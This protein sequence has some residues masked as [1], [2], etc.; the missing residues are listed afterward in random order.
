[1]WRSIL[2]VILMP[3][4]LWAQNPQEMGAEGKSQTP[5]S[6]IVEQKAPESTYQAFTQ[7]QAIRRGTTEKA[8]LLFS[9][10][11]DA[12]ISPR[13]RGDKV[14]PLK[15][16]FTSSDGLRIS[17]FEFPPDTKNRFDLENERI[18]LIWG[19]EAAVRFKVSA[20][21]NAT[22]GDRVLQGKLTYQ[23][24]RD[25]VPLPAQEIAVQLP[26]TV[27]DHD[28]AANKNP[29]Y[30]QRFGGTPMLVWILAPV[31][32]PIVAVIILGCAIVR[33]DCSE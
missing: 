14:I 31:L 33:I 15:L 13:Y 18:P 12:V 29:E 6:K 2:A 11:P 20:S 3:T 28:A 24:V 1:M 5:D 32:I 4:L 9:L 16:E 27:V 25:N 7:M 17:S 21:R 30:K 10:G 26:L 22:L 23:I 8:A 19:A